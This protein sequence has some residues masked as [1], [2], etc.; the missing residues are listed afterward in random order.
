MHIS[1]ESATHFRVVSDFTD[2]GVRLCVLSFT[3][4]SDTPKGCWIKSIFSRKR[5]V[6]NSS[7]KR[8]AHPTQEAALAAFVARN[9]CHVQILKAQLE[10]AE[11]AG[12]LARE[13]KIQGQ[14]S[15]VHLSRLV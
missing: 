12:E 1:P 15:P 9:K 13:G 14:H 4:I 6:S 11:A 2:R 10:R 8:Y 7:R 5:W 3:K